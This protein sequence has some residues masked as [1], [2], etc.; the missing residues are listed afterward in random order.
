MSGCQVTKHHIVYD[1]I[2]EKQKGKLILYIVKE[3][4]ISTIKYSEW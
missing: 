3:K 4:E 1:L 2:L